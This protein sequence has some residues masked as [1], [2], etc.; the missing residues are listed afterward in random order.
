[1]TAHWVS[2]RISPS[3]LLD[4][5]D[6]GPESLNT[7][8][9][10]FAAR[11]DAQG[12]ARTIVWTRPDDPTVVA[13]YS[14]AP[15][16]VRREGLTRAAH[17]GHSV[18]PAYLLSRLALDRSLQGGGLGTYLL[19]HAV[20]LVVAA[21]TT[22]GG[23]LLVVDAIDDAASSFYRAHAFTPISGTRRLYARI[24]SL[25]AC[26]TLVPRRNARLFRGEGSPRLNPTDGR[27]PSVSTC[28][29]ARPRRTTQHAL[30]CTSQSHGVVRHALG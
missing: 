12:T 21:S 18:I 22:G 2:S 14:V 10:Q 24:S 15:T 1:M 8:L 4:G 17:G 28:R 26:S 23:R 13:Y 7:W 30:R 27:C 6:S 9:K 3:H 19:L 29:D 5:F 16:E 11:A 20:E 25:Q